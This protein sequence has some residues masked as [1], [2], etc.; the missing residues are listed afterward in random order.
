MDS[1]EGATSATPGSPPITQITFPACRA[2][3]PGGPNRCLSVSSLSARPS[4]VNWR[5]GI[6]DF[7]FGA[8][9]SFTRVTACRVACPPKGGLSPEASTQLLTNWPPAGNGL[10]IDCQSAAV[11][12][13]IENARV[14][15]RYSGSSVWYWLAASSWASCCWRSS[16]CTWRKAGD[17][18]LLTEPIFR[19]MPSLL[20]VDRP[21][22][23]RSHGAATGRRLRTGSICLRVSYG[24]VS[25]LFTVGAIRRHPSGGRSIGVG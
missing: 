11:Q 8:C 21:P 16:A 5:V 24:V 10:I 9:S 4:P 2:Q 17:S 23:P 1:V 20:S 15:R 3:Y 25:T 6:H 13:G 22:V 12:P 19:T 18:N 7:T 14:A